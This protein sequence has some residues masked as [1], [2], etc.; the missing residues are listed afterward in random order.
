MS[1]TIH[2]ARPDHLL[3]EIDH[4]FIEISGLPIVDN[5]LKCIGVLSKKDK[6]KASN[7]LKTKV[8]EVMTSPLISLLADKQ[9]QMLQF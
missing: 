5:D 2:F 1:T 4:H 7:G 8:R 9:F 3:E 6:V